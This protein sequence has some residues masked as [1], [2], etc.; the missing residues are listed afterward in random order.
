MLRKW[1]K[2]T[3]EI[4][5]TFYILKYRKTTIAKEPVCLNDGLRTSKNRC[6]S[7]YV[8][9][10]SILNFFFYQFASDAFF[11]LTLFLGILILTLALTSRTTR[12][13]KKK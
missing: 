11:H 3:K 6:V 12:E 5:P 2:K 9:K 10:Y 1:K 7:N 8:V 13:R 4:L